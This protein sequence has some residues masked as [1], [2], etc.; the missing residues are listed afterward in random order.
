MTKINIH[1]NNSPLTVQSRDKK[2]LKSI[3]DNKIFDKIYYF[4]TW[5]DSLKLE[6]ELY[7]NVTVFRVKTPFFQNPKNNITKAIKLFIWLMKI[8]FMLRKVKIS[9][10]NCHSLAILPFCSILK[11][12]KRC[13][14]IYDTHELETE[15][16]ASKGL[17]KVLA[18]ITERFFYKI[19]R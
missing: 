5:E 15:T 14:L 8:F 7:N 3:H 18:K 4:G 16:N 6:E 19:C 12:I 2:I 1:I 11:K 13:N 10:I 17:R 9:C